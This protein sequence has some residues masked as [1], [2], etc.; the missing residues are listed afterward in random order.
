MHYA[1][2]RWACYHY[3]AHST[4][5]E[6]RVLSGRWIAAHPWPVLKG[7]WG[8]RISTGVDGPRGWNSAIERRSWVQVWVRSLVLFPLSPYPVWA[9]KFTTYYIY[10]CCYLTHCHM[11]LYLSCHCVVPPLPLT[12]PPPKC[13]RWCLSPVQSGWWMYHWF[14]SPPRPLLV[15]CSPPLVEWSTWQCRSQLPQQEPATLL[16][17]L[18]KCFAHH[19]WHGHPALCWDAQQL[20]WV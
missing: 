11:L 9:V 1:S 6:A 8:R 14:P 7:D 4:S 13:S 3:T 12:R 2:R 5:L 18:E 20:E 17:E 16:S 10:N 19:E 15:G